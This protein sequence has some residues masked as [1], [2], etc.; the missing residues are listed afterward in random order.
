MRRMTRGMSAV[1]LTLGR[2]IEIGAEGIGADQADGER[3]AGR[4][5]KHCQANR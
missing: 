1:M 5:E 4:R 3:C 2:T